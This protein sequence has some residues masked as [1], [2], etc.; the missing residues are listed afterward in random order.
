MKEKTAKKIAPTSPVQSKPWE[1]ISPKLQAKIVEEVESG[2]I[3]HR[4]A[5]RKY[6]V[7]RT[8]LSLWKEKAKLEKL[9]DP[10]R[11]ENSNAMEETVASTALI[12][13]V[14]DL[15]SALEQSQL[16]ILAL[17]T[18]ISI[19]EKDYSIKIRKK[20]GTKPSIE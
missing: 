13:K 12:K 18:M 17:E 9:I 14:H 19:A 20:R 4:A 15:T 6:G 11:V 8:V 5:V 16:K 7:S 1:R 2:L 3:G 10:K